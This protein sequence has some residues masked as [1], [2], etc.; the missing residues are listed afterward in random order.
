MRSVINLIKAF[1][2]SLLFIVVMFLVQGCIIKAANADQYTD[3]EN[4]ARDAF[5][6]QSGLQKLGNDTFNYLKSNYVDSNPFTKDVGGLVGGS[7]YIYKH[8]SVRVR[9]SNSCKLTVA[10]YNLGLEYHW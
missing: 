3:A 2:I 4:H 6:I 1:I 7:W 8:R 10:P 9:L 5:L